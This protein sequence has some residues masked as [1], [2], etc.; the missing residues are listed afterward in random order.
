MSSLVLL[1][2][3]LSKQHAG[4]RLNRKTGAVKVRKICRTVRQMGYVSDKN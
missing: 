3:T 1:K 2:V 4:N